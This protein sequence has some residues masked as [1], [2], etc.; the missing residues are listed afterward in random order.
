MSAAAQA[1]GVDGGG[2]STVTKY[3]GH[4]HACMHMCVGGQDQGSQGCQATQ[5]LTR[6]RS[7]AARIPGIHG[8]KQPALKGQRL[9]AF[10]EITLEQLSDRRDA[11]DRRATHRSVCQPPGLCV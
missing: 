4:P 2:S 3:K 7:H 5:A 11:S 6:Q 10:G 1:E 8:I 9:E